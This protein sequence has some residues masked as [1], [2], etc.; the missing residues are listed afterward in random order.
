VRG[1]VD[2]DEPSVVQQLT[3]PACGREITVNLPYR[4]KPE[5]TPVSSR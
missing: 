1:A 5:G 3:C 4:V 2:S